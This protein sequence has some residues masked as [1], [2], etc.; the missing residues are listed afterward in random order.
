MQHSGAM[1]KTKVR[2]VVSK[3]DPAPS[4]RSSYMKK[5]CTEKKIPAS[6]DRAQMQQQYISCATSSWEL[7]SIS[8]QMFYFCFVNAEVKVAFKWEGE[9]NS[10]EQFCISIITSACHLWSFLCKLH[11]CGDLQPVKPSVRVI[12]VTTSSV[13][14]DFKVCTQF[15]TYS[16]QNC[17]GD[18]KS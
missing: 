5:N 11:G 3:T 2:V 8:S 16:N 7:L 17:S 4:M 6:Y 15:G 14:S 10:E 9:G 18:L 1:E 12:P 13:I